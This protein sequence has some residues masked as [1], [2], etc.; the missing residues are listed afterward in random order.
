MQEQDKL[1]RRPR[2]RFERLNIVIAILIAGWVP[3]ILMLTVSYT[4][5]TRTLE[6]QIQRDR[7]SFVQ[8]IA[9]LVGDDLSRSG[10][11]AEFYQ[12]YPPVAKIFTARYPD[13]AAKNWLQE[14][15]F[16]HPRIDGMFITTEDGR[17]I[18]SVP[19]DPAMMLDDRISGSVSVPASYNVSMSPIHPRSSDNR[20]ATDLVSPIRGPDGTRIGFIGVSVL[21][22]RI[23][24]R[25][26]TINFADQA[27]CQIVDQNGAALFGNDFKANPGNISD[28]TK[29]LLRNS[30]RQE[31]THRRRHRGTFV[32]LLRWNRVV[33]S[34]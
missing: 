32:P 28:A 21:V 8:L 14:T 12:S 13:V 6:S 15:Y 26:S 7:Q 11:I 9:H 30:L 2:G 27:K 22:E 16:T 29:T 18:S 20:L 23:G 31:R 17:L 3:S 1:R 19:D 25:L 10:A 5:L 34:R 33:G 24:R 4:I